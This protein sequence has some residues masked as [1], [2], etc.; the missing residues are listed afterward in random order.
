M[1][2]GLTQIQT[3]PQTIEKALFAIRD[4]PAR[5]ARLW[6]KPIPVPAAKPVAVKPI[7][8]VPERHQFVSA[9]APAPDVKRLTSSKV[10]DHGKGAPPKF[11][12]PSIHYIKRVVAKEYNVSICDLESERRTIDVVRPRQ[13]ASYLSAT[14]THRSLPAIGRALGDR[15]H[16]TILHARDKI[17]GLT[18]RHGDFARH[19]NEIMYEILLTFNDTSFG[20]AQ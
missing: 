9:P 4:R 17:H 19:V 1:R 10:A 11:P 5:L 15:D 16:S 20:S 6:P 3:E 8:A 18:L 7:P 13:I 2:M 14:M 12:V